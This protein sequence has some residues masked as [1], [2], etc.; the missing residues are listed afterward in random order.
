MLP[1]SALTAQ[2][3]HVSGIVQGVGF[4][5]FVYRLATAHGLTGWVLNGERGVHIHAEGSAEVLADFTDAIRAQA[6]PAAHVTGLEV[7]T[8]APEQFCGFEIRQSAKQARPTVRVSPDLPICD[9][10]LAELFDPTDRRHGY[11]YIN[12]TDCGPRYSII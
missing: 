5:P 12:C 6:P 10:C 2:E 7:T 8:V 4:R 9:A 3:I 11:P 1:A